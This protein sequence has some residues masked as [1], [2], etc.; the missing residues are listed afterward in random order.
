MS[1]NCIGEK[2]VEGFAEGLVT[3]KTL[4]CLSLKDNK[5][6]DGSGQLLL[7]AVAINQTLTKLNLQLNSIGYKY[8]DA[9]EEHIS[10]NLQAYK[11][12]KLPLI[13]NK[14]EQI[15]DELGEHLT[16]EA[17]KLDIQ[18]RKMEN[19]RLMERE[20]KEF[21]CVREIEE[22]AGKTL[23]FKKNKMAQD[24]RKMD[25]HTKEIED[26]IRVIYTIYIYIYIVY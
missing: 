6:M 21:Q 7:H 26:N 2:G 13:K 17:Y 1:N 12:Q 16:V 20:E 9:I 11:K 5:L 22:Y 14:L 18:Q 10:R 4:R 25:K 19:E 24:G 23:Q 15:K 8:I 3:N